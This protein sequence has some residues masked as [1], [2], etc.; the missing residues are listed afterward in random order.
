MVPYTWHVNVVTSNLWRHWWG[1]LGCH[2][3]PET[4]WASSHVRHICCVNNKAAT[5]DFDLR[6]LAYHIV[7]KFGGF[8]MCRICLKI[9]LANCPIE[10]CCNRW[11]NCLN[12]DW[13]LPVYVCCLV[14]K[15]FG[16]PMSVNTS[17]VSRKWPIRRT[18]T[19][20]ASGLPSHSCCWAQVASHTCAPLLSPLTECHT[21]TLV[22]P[23][24]GT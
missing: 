19:H 6:I 7:G 9:Y 17:A 4:M 5:A 21:R 12:E 13:Y 18:L 20:H 11:F 10:L 3:T 23:V 24:A 2:R 8:K 15:G 16:C 14:A 22:L 1:I